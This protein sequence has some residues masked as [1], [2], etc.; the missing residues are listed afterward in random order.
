MHNLRH[1]YIWLH[2]LKQIHADTGAS[3][4]WSKIWKKNL[5]REAGG[6]ETL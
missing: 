1:Y 5:E 4:F 2:K 3:G 6:P